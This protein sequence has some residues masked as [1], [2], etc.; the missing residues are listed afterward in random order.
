VVVRDGRQF[1]V[2]SGCTV[3]RGAG[4]LPV[5]SLSHDRNARICRVVRGRSWRCVG[6][7]AAN[8]ECS[9]ATLIARGRA[10]G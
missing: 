4:H 2:L 6:V 3:M 10:S 9:V 7:H 1:S 8:S 5:P